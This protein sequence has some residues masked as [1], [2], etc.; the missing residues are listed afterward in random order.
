MS[1]WRSFLHFVQA[2]LDHTPWSSGLH[3]KV[4]CRGEVIEADH[5]FSSE[6]L[7]ATSVEVGSERGGVEAGRGIPVTFM[8]KE[9]SGKQRK[10]GARGRWDVGNW[11]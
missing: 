7:W 5:I 1:C 10:P 2:G 9:A 3:D 11:E 6:D 8:K 4:N